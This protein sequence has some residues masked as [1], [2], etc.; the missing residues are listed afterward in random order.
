MPA[1]EVKSYDYRFRLF[2]ESVF[3][4]EIEFEADP[5]S[6]RAMDFLVSWDPERSFRAAVGGDEED[7]IGEAGGLGTLEAD[8]ARGC[9]RGVVRA[10]LL[11]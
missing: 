3:G 8:E 9:S 4:V 1:I 2:E 5:A 6:L 10:K 7:F 11:R